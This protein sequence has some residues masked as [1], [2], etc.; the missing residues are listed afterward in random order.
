MFAEQVERTAAAGDRHN[1]QVDDETLVFATPV[2]W[3]EAEHTASV[4]VLGLSMDAV[5]A[6]L[7]N[8]ALLGRLRLVGNVLG[9]AANRLAHALQ[10]PSDAYVGVR[11]RPPSDRRSFAF[12]A[13]ALRQAIGRHVVE[14]LLQSRVLEARE[15][16][17]G[18][19]VLARTG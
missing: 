16:E 7:D 15:V 1:Q 5:G 3:R 9:V 2:L 12:R 17:D 11:T 18:E 6:T 14:Q 8:Q 13:V 10:L 19:Y 4:G